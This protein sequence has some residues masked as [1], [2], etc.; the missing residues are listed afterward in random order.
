MSRIARNLIPDNQIHIPTKNYG[1]PA[2]R[3]LSGKYFLSGILEKI[4]LAKSQNR[5]L[6]N[7]YC[8][9]LADKTNSYL[10]IEKAISL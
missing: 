2:K 8:K 5:K 9:T 6:Q 1:H 7:K 10:F 4:S 3:K